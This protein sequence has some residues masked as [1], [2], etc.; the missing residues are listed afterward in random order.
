MSDDEIKEIGNK[1]DELHENFYHSNAPY[2]ERY[3]AFYDYCESV[4]KIMEVEYKSIFDKFEYAPFYSKDWWKRKD[5]LTN[6]EQKNII[7][8]I[9]DYCYEI[10]DKF[11]TPHFKDRLKENGMETNI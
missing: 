9:I 5:N 3:Y 8:Q 6:E 7:V 1:L 2:H 10:I 4:L 11:N